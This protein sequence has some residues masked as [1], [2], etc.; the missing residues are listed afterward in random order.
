MLWLGRYH[1][2]IIDASGDEPWAEAG[3]WHGWQW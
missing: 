1:P 2:T 3:N